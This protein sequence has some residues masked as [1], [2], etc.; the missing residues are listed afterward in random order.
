MRAWIWST[1]LVVLAAT[2]AAAPAQSYTV[3]IKGSPAEGK[4]IAVSETLKV[5]LAFNVAVGGNVIKEEKKVMTEEQQ[6]TE[7]ILEADAKGPV[8]FTRDY[9]KAAKGE[10]DD[11]KN[12]SYAGKTITFER[13]GEQFEATAADVEAKGEL[14]ELAKKV[15]TKH[16]DEALAPKKS[17]QVGDTWPIATETISGFL[18][19]M[20]GGADL[21]KLKAQGKLLKAYKKDGQ[22]WATLEITGSVPLNKFGP[23]PLDKPLPLQM[24]ITLDAPIDGSS[25]ANQARVQMTIKGASQV[26]M[27]GQTIMLDVVVQADVRREQSAEK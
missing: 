17:V 10:N 15:S 13:K 1:A 5:N 27:N 16:A 3:K 26:E 12:R 21:E 22:Q 4:S 7:K 19:D 20:K 25:T 2:A 18:G 6:Y 8:R 14:A 24:K 23:L 11:Q 9:N